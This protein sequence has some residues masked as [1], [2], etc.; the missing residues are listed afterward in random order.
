M[1]PGQIMSMAKALSLVSVQ[2]VWP[3][4]AWLNAFKPPRTRPLGGQAALTPRG[5][6]VE[7]LRR[8]TPMRSAAQVSQAHE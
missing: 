4:C 3:A 7:G 6:N 2:A 8:V 1:M 5:R